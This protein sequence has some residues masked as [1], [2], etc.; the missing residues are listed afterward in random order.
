MMREEPTGCIEIYRPSMPFAKFRAYSI[1]VDGKKAG[2]VKDD[3]TLILPVS[4]GVHDLWGKMDWKKSNIA[5]INVEAGKITRI[6]VGLKRKIGVKLLAQMALWIVMIVAGAA[7][8]I[9]V[10]IGIGAAGIFMTR[11]GNP[12]LY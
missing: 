8:G 5:R 12:Y 6:T 7:L 11:V 1:F 2:A 4:P 3:A 9:A 10:L